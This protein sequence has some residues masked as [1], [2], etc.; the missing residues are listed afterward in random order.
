MSKEYLRSGVIFVTFL[1]KKIVVDLISKVKWISYIL[2]GNTR[3]IENSVHFGKQRYRKDEENIS[4]LCLEYTLHQSVS[5][6]VFYFLEIPQ[7]LGQ[8]IALSKYLLNE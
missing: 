8:C 4:V 7:R 5:F 3:F 6:S 1:K 2:S